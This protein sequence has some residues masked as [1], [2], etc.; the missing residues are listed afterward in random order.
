MEREK[1]K[2][3]ELEKQKKL[4]EEKR[5]QDD[6]ERE[7]AEQEAARTGI[8]LKS[9]FVSDVILERM[10]VSDFPMFAMEFSE[11]WSVIGCAN[12]KH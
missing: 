2:K 3:E 4:Q 8:P 1:A 10:S 7:K 5:K 12:D 9:K 11:N 6:E